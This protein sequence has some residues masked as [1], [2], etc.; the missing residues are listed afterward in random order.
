MNHETEFMFLIIRHPDIIYYPAVNFI[1]T[2]EPRS[3]IWDKSTC[4]NGG[5]EA[6]YRT[7]I[8]V[9]FSA[10]VNPHGNL[11][12]LGR[13]VTICTTKINVYYFCILSTQCISGFRGILRTNADYF[14]EQLY[15]LSFIIEKQCVFLEVKTVLNF[16]LERVHAPFSLSSVCQVRH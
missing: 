13:T 9:P 15:R 12:F 1:L 3:N 8:R 11:I 10:Y 16:L 14:P 7:C 5:R 2:L 6:V 4:N